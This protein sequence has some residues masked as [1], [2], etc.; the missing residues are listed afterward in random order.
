MLNAFEVQV[1]EVRIVGDFLGNKGS[2]LFGWWFWGFFFFRIY[3]LEK[4]QA[5]LY[6]SGRSEEGE[7]ISRTLPAEHRA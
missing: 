7:R 5:C 4:E 2:F 6:V 3:L 1:W